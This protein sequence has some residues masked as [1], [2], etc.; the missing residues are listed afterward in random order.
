MKHTKGMKH[1]SLII[2]MMLMFTMTFG[3][4]AS[5]AS[6]TKSMYVIYKV[7]S[8]VRYEGETFSDSVKI[9]YNKGLIS[10]VK[11]DTMYFQYY[12]NSNGKITK[13]KDLSSGRTYGVK[14][15]RKGR[16]IEA[17]SY[18]PYSGKKMWGLVKYAY[19]SKNRCTKYVVSGDT[20]NTWK[21]RYNSKGQLTK[22][23]F[24]PFGSFKNGYEM[25]RYTY[26]KKGKVKKAKYSTVGDEKYIIQDSSVTNYKNK[27]SNGRLKT[28]VSDNGATWTFYY[29]KVN[30]PKKY[31]KRIKAE[32]SWI[33]NTVIG[34]M[35]YDLLAVN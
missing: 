27:Y 12:R 22:A 7:K 32:Q 11:N 18:E 10:K 20:I 17:E 25:Y 35:D 24:S 3:T 21:Y 5:Q 28:V 15:D 8:T 29:K 33:R 19:D 4:F 34:V 2:T 16:I 9:S 6:S 1:L 26:D 14:K 13:S 23:K 31:V 30:V